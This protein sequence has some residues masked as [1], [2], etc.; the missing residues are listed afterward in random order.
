MTYGARICSFS[1]P[2]GDMPHKLRRDQE[3]VLS[4]L[5]EHPRFS[6]FDVDA[7]IGRTL[8]ELTTR[9]RIRHHNEKE[10][11]PWCRVEVLPPTVPCPTC[12]GTGGIA[13]GLTGKWKFRAC[14]QCGGERFVPAQ[15]PALERAAAPTHGEPR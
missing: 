13:T 3:A 1:G 8:E 7:K 12:D 14:G 15:P 2:L 10:S 4:V 11:Y 9:R 6:V 5:L